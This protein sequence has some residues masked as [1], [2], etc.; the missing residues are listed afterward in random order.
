MRWQLDGVFH[1]EGAE[2]VKWDL[3]FSYFCTGKWDLGHWD[4]ESQTQKL[5]LGKTCLEITQHIM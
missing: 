2:G 4:W 5:G 1:S 3:G